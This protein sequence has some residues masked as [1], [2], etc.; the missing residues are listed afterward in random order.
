MQ[1][2]KLIIIIYVGLALAGCARS[3]PPTKKARREKSAWQATVNTPFTDSAIKAYWVELI[4]DRWNF[5]KEEKSNLSPDDVPNL[6][7]IQSLNYTM[8][9]SSFANYSKKQSIASILLLDRGSIVSYAV[10]NDSVVAV[11]FPKIINGKW[12]NGGGYTVPFKPLSNKLSAIYKEGG[13]VYNIKVYASPARSQG[14]NYIVTYKND[15]F[16]SITMD[17]SLVPLED[18]LLKLK[19]RID[20][21]N[22]MLRRGLEK[23]IPAG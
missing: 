22:D 20:Y 2:S 19:Q 9:S 13:E 7:F 21:I 5:F 11:V 18:E 1:Y 3:F 16:M 23:E 12:G 4:G 14:G 10:K 6:K 17:G 15:K 8:D